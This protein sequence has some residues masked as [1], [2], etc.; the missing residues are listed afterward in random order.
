[1][2]G[3]RSREILR[4]LE[5]IQLKRCGPAGTEMVSASKV[6][7]SRDSPGGT[8]DRSGMIQSSRWCCVEQNFWPPGGGR[9]GRGGDDFHVRVG[10]LGPETGSTLLSEP[11]TFRTGAGTRG[12]FLVGS[13]SGSTGCTSLSVG[14]VKW[15]LQGDSVQRPDELHPA[16]DVDR[17]TDG[18]HVG[19]MHACTCRR[20]HHIC[21][22][23]SV[24]G[25]GVVVH[26][27]RGRPS[28]GILSDEVAP[29]PAPVPSYPLPPPSR[30]FGLSSVDGEKRCGQGG[31]GAQFQSGPYKSVPPT[32]IF[33]TAS[34]VW[35]DPWGDASGE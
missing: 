26:T 6:E 3:W 18:I 30:P 10:R 17:L 5:Q 31:G 19:S 9:R 27:R 16:E 13:R 2:D 35:Q 11:R 25:R 15:I 23:A 20:R 28:E 21:L 7:R 33:G 34:A 32:R 14:G 29:V 24:R 22:P 8:E 12:G 1:M 4:D